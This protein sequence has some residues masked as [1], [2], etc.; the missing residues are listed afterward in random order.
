[1]LPVLAPTTSLSNMTQF[2]ET[3]V[4]KSTNWFRAT[5][6]YLHALLAPTANETDD[7]L[8]AYSRQSKSKITARFYPSTSLY[9]SAAK[10]HH[11]VTHF[12]HH[13]YIKFSLELKFVSR[14]GMGVS[15]NLLIG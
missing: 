10:F 3:N 7:M 12:D 14:L 15:V 4:N 2:P 1:M 6:I 5:T 9:F 11:F 8:S 13:R